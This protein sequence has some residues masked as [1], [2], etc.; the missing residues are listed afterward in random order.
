MT[1]SAF[2]AI[3]RWCAP[4]AA[5]TALAAGLAA[6][7]PVRPPAYI[8]QSTADVEITLP[9]P[10]GPAPSVLYRAPD[11]S[12][13][14]AAAET[15]DGTSLAVRL[16]AARISPG[17]TFLVPCVPPEADLRDAA[18]PALVQCLLDGA[19]AGSGA[20]LDLGGVEA[21]PREITLRVR[22]EASPLAPDSLTVVLDGVPIPASPPAVELRLPDPREGV[23]TVRL[24]DAGT[25]DGRRTTLSVRIADCGLATPPLTWS[26]AFRRAPSWTL[27]DGR[28]LSVDTVTDAPGWETW[29]VIAD[30]RTM[31]E[32]DG[33]TAGRTWLSEENDRPH[34]VRVS[35]PS[36]RTVTGVALWWAFYECYRT[37]VAYE[38]QT[39]DGTR[40]VTRASVRD[41]PSQQCSRHTF[42]SVTTDSVR[43][44]Q[45]P[46]SGP[47]GRS[48]YMWLSEVEVLSP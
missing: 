48:G 37:S 19:D 43:V 10:P 24:P 40:W 26:L 18:P 20:T 42:S 16:E 45:P 5:A 34:W 23:L 28:T 22:D 2:R 39:W 25:A 3:L 31:K 13:A 33:T 6:Q 11:G 30:G 29:Q 32:G 21:P 38:V 8:V 35:F 47:P 9:L 1:C 14:P 17:G 12:W 44:W 27:P 7:P 36:P 46:R 4:A 41:Q 15:R